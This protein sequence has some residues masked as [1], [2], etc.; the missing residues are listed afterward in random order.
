MV[1]RRL[2]EGFLSEVAARVGSGASSAL[3]PDPVRASAIVQTLTPVASVAG[4]A[5]TTV[6]VNGRRVDVRVV[7][8]G[9][10]WW[11]VCSIDTEGV[12]HASSFER[13]P[14]FSGVEGG[15]AVI[16]NGPSSVGKS[17]TM[18]AVL[19][20]ATTPWVVFD[21]LS[22]GTVAMP[23]LI[24]PETAPSLG[25]GFVA[26]I[27][28]LAAAG[29]QVITTGGPPSRLAP[30]RT[31]VPTLAV[32]LDCP[33]SVRVERQGARKDRWGGLTEETEDAHDGWTY[34]LRFDTSRTSPDE[35]AG[36]ILAA[37]G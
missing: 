10:E 18:S 4:G 24:W 31:A 37:L 23:F 36:R 27:V 11:V 6:T 9:R 17:T 21:E 34:D 3:T 15:R 2:V 32:G 22:F 26:G 30:L 20:H 28:A 16:V 13:P 7:A 1:D 29:N 19:R 25:R 5:L 12:H 35:I 8:P 14:S 33:R